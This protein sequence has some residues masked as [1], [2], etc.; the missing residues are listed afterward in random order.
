VSR[1]NKLQRTRLD[2]LDR[3]LQD[4]HRHGDDGAF[5][6]LA[7]E[8]AA[9]LC[10][11]A[12]A[13]LYGEVV[14]RALRRALAAGDLARTEWI[15]RRLLRE[16]R[17]RPL[18]LAAAAVDHLA[19]GRAEEARLA[20]ASLAAGGAEVSGGGSGGAPATPPPLLVQALAALCPP[21]E[22]TAPALPAQAGTPPARAGPTDLDRLGEAVAALAASKAGSPAARQP[23]R[24]VRLETPEA[25]AVWRFYLG[26]KSLETRGSPPATA[27]IGALGE[28]LAAL[29]AALGGDRALADLLGDADRGLHLLGVISSAEGVIRRPPRG[30][31][32]GGSSRHLRV[33]L[34]LAREIAKPLSSVLRADP[35]PPLLEP[36]RRAVRERWRSLLA[37]AIEQPG[38]AAIWAELYS[39]SPPLFSLDLE[40]GSDPSPEGGAQALRRWAK[41]RSLLSAQSFGELARWLALTAR[42]EPAPERLVQLWAL[43]LWAWDRE[44]EKEESAEAPV[45]PGVTPPLMN[46]LVRL[47]QMASECPH[48]IPPEQ[49]RE[50][51]RILAEQLLGLC[52]G[53]QFCRSMTAAAE[54]LL[55]HLPDDPRLLVVGLAAAAC[56]S[57]P[58]AAH[59]FASRITA[60]GAVGGADQEQVFRLVSEIVLEPAEVAVSILRRLRPLLPEESWPRARSLMVGEVTGTLCSSLRRY[61]CDLDFGLLRRDVELCR[62]ALGDCTELAALAAA[63]ACIEPTAGA[64]R[65]VL[66]QDLARLPGLEP[67]LIAFRVLAEASR[68]GGPRVE[69]AFHESRGIALD[70]LDGRWRLWQ[71]VLVPLLVGASPRQRQRLR[72]MVREL[73]GQQGASESDRRAYTSILEEIEVLARFERRVRRELDWMPHFDPSPGPSPD[74]RGGPEAGRRRRSRPKAAAGDQLSLDLS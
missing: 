28:S 60:R 16:A 56:S 2:E 44:E 20:L 9:D 12:A 17:A 67:A 3:R 36:L 72:S 24:G 19:A 74:R 66:R 5:V 58:D 47:E 55:L 22:P 1:K 31:A 13:S 49:Q 39:I 41:A 35:W 52:E 30:R 37:W 7:R 4:F 45:A 34:D 63:A 70:R 51:A 21:G 59:R 8:R 46:A 26:L 15:L 68:D 40:L 29:R 57:N 62:A 14:D 25:Q 10:R 32:A 18:A 43:E 38:A 11:C 69:E 33:L 6:E 42:A 65:L 61:G 54:S 73:R 23:A 27:E 64:T 50:V 71:P 53:V 48:R